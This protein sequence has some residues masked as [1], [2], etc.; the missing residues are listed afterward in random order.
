[1]KRLTR[2]VGKYKV[3]RTVGKGT[4]AKVK[5]ACNTET[6]E[7]VAMKV[8]AKSSIL[9]HKMVLIVFMCIMTSLSFGKTDDCDN[10]LNGFARIYWSNE[11][12]VALS[13]VEGIQPFHPS[14]QKRLRELFVQKE[15]LNKLKVLQ[16]FIEAVKPY[17]R[18]LIDL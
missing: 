9:K 1:M 2:K 3:G 10:S 11:A 12:M 7:G 6:G 13:M 17:L 4:F 14:L 16:E 15:R 5:F 18:Q 8:L